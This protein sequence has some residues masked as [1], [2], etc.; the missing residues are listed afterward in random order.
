MPG[1]WATALF[2]Y[3]S[4]IIA[5]ILSLL[6]GT[7]SASTLTDPAGHMWQAQDIGSVTALLCL[8]TALPFWLLAVFEIGRDRL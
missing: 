7:E 1:Y 5:P 2:A 4:I 8:F 6:L 3:T